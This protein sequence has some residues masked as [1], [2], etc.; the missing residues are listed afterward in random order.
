MTEEI[1]QTTQ[2]IPLPGE[3][4]AKPRKPD[5]LQGDEWFE[6]QV[7]EDFLD[8][9]EPYRPPRYTMERGGVP[10]AD[11]GE[12]HIISGKPGNGKTGL[13]S[14]L[15]AATLG[16][17]FGNTIAREVGHIVRD[18]EGNIVVGGD[19]RP[20]F[21][22]RPTRIL[23]IDTEQGKDDTIAFK[24]RVISMSG[25]A[26]Q[27]AKEHF[28][29][30]RLRD[31]ELAQDRWK[32]ILKAIY[33]V[34]PTDIFLDGMLDIVEDYNDQKECQPII[35]KCMMLAT[36][37]DTSLWAVLHENPMVDKL[38]GT[39]GSITQRK[40]SEIFT[41]IKVKQAD[42]KENDRRADLPDIYFRVKQNKA[43][44]RDVSDWLFQYVTNAGGWGQPVEIEDNGVR[45]ADSKEIAFMKEADERLK[46]FNWTSAGA[47]YTELERYLRK[48]V[49]GR[50]AGDL[51]NIAAEHGI[52]YKSDKKKYH[53]NGIKELPKDNAQD[54]P[55]EGPGN[56]EV[57]Y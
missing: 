10:F 19:K 4:D 50:R 41:V 1:Q 17:Q 36:Y 51:I 13:M 42:L 39:L 53:Y 29:I 35:R 52:I 44:G 11:V 33:V 37:Y 46:A 31:T 15:E 47:T 48:S 22:V 5:F 21:A 28:F 56:E 8:F 30:L 2:G 40:V 34:Q 18:A 27:E 23:H 9:D 49:S 24:N 55:F 43:R 6:T 3:P 12:L 7:D 14:Q 54:L 20:T 25:V 32:K 16:R 26:A 45:V 57:P 38:V